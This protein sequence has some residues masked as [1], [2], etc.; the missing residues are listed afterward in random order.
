MLTPKRQSSFRK[1]GIII[2]SLCL[3]FVFA[4]CDYMTYRADQK[5][6]NAIADYIIKDSDDGN[7]KTSQLSV[8]EHAKMV[9]LAFTGVADLEHADNIAYAMNTYLENTPDC[10][11]NTEGY[12]IRILAEN[13]DELNANPPDYYTHFYAY[14][15]SEPFNE[16]FEVVD[17][18]DLLIDSIDVQISQPFSV[19]EFLNCKVHYEHI[20]FSQDADF[21]TMED[22]ADTEWIQSICLKES[23]EGQGSM[24]QRSDTPDLD[25]ETYVD[26]CTIADR[27]NSEKGYKFASAELSDDTQTKWQ[28]EYGKDF[29]I[30]EHPPVL[31]YT[32]T[33]N[34]DY[35]VTRD[36]QDYTQGLCWYIECD[37]EHVLTRAANETVLT[38]L[39]NWPD[40]GNYKI[41]MIAWIDGE[42]VRVSNIIEYTL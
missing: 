26:Y 9:N 28:E 24:T 11:I 1:A 36:E 31:I 41:Y 27:I 40:T 2:L 16:T 4:S 22:L 25:Y 8:N 42:Y 10:F 15:F 20:T 33:L 18:Q 38:P 14:L 17:K 5:E 21:D 35:T 3:I 29:V 23:N 13:Y 6:L 39:P 32:L 37:G 30:I 12:K 34:E 19:S 7:I